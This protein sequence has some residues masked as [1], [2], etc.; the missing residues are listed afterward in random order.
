MTD[1]FSEIISLLHPKAS[2]SKLS[3]ASGPFRVCRDD[4]NETFYSSVLSGRT[5]L[6]VP[7][8]ES[9]ELSVGDFVLIPAVKAFTFSS[10][11]PEPSSDLL[12]HP[13]EGE[14][15][16]FRIGPPD[17]TPDVQQLIGHCTF[18]SPDAELLVSLLPDLIVVRGEGR[19]AALGGLV[20]D[21]ARAN[22]PARDVIVE[23]LL[24]VL[25]IEAFRTGSDPDTTVGLLRGL[26][27]M[28][29]GPSLR[30]IHAAPAHNWS[31]QELA[32]E[33]GLSR[34]AF[35]SRFDLIMGQTPMGY[36]MGW[37]MTLAKHMLRADKYSIADVA[38]KI[39][40]GSSSAFSTAFARYV[41]FPPARYAKSNAVG[42]ISP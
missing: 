29:I 32:K 30:A 27:D 41:G 9:V 20:R 14:D 8:K 19:L 5:L 23:H 31:V 36:V 4:V 37:R 28:R 24:K 1:P 26:A 40:Y 16:I 35:F 21:E 7:G 25:L 2:H 10:M 12:S 18:A 33:A 6:E 13:V 15:G 42:V 17:A 11:D 38:A 34:S 39:G 3:H 22:R